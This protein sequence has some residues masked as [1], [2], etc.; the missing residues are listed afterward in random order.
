MILPCANYPQTCQLVRELSEHHRQR[1]PHHQ[2]RPLPP[3]A[4]A[5]PKRVKAGRVDMSLAVK[6][7]WCSPLQPMTKT[8]DADY[9]R[10]RREN[11]G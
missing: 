4:A 11:G 9:A 1:T 3:S 2:R 5:R 7:G 6:M 8:T 10:I